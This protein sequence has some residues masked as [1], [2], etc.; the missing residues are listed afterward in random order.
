MTI[1]TT[2]RLEILASVEIHLNLN[3]LEARHCLTTNPLRY[4]DGFNKAD[5]DAGWKQISAISSK[6]VTEVEIEA[7]K[8]EA[9][10]SNRAYWLDLTAMY[11]DTRIIGN[12]NHYV[13]H[14]LGVGCGFN[15]RAFRV[16]WLDADRLPLTC[17][18]STQGEIPGWLRPQFPDNAHITNLDYL[19]AE[20]PLLSRRRVKRCLMAAG[21]RP[22]EANE[23]LRARDA[24][25]DYDHWPSQALRDVMK[26]GKRHAAKRFPI[27]V[28]ID[29]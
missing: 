8:A 1:T 19:L 21:L 25:R 14:E 24:D 26:R 16:A 12:G 27:D 3:T 29:D 20:R 11:K 23:F 15:G 17:N 10:D 18:L 5:S 9:I 28:H 13:A 4:H 7:M 6:S 22:S 2:C